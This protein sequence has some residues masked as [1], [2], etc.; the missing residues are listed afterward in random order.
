MGNKKPGDQAGKRGGERKPPNQKTLSDNQYLTQK[1][2]CRVLRQSNRNGIYRCKTIKAP[3][4]M[5]ML[6]NRH[7]AL[8]SHAPA[9]S[10][11]LCLFRTQAYQRY[12]KRGSIRFILVY[13]GETIKELECSR[14]TLFNF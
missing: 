4:S 3:K 9:W 5:G 11:S 7:K 12:G 10:T 1:I 8:E 2:Q 14:P 6:W 13:L